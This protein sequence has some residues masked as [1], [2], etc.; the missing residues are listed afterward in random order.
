MGTCGVLD[1]CLCL[2][3]GGVGGEWVEFGPGSEK[4]RWCYVCVGCEWILCV[5]SRSRYLYIVIGGYLR[6]LGASS[7]QSCGTPLIYVSY[8]V[9]VYGIYC[10]SRLVCVL[11]DLDLSG[12]NPPL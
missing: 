11:S 12:H 7:V 10:K 3:C 6:I 1:V 9:F 4:V 8:C 2:G 5:D